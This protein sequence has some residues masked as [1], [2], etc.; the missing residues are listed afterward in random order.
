MSELKHPYYIYSPDYRESSGGIQ[1][2]HKLCHQINL[3]GGQAWMVSCDIINPSWNTPILDVEIYNEHKKAELIPVA[4]YSE[5]YSGNPINADVCV[6]YML[7][8]EALLNGNRLNE[9]EE[10][11]FFWYS[12]QL[13]VKE[14]HV[15]FLTM[16]GPDLE[17]FSEDGREK[18]TKLLY[19]NRVPEEKVDF[20]AL[21]EDI[22]IISVRNPRPLAELAEILKSATVMYTFEWSGTCNLAA[23]C[24]VPVV[25]LVARGYEK[26]A[27]SDASIRD[28]GGAGVCFSDDPAELQRTRS[29]LYKVRDHMRKFEDNFSQQLMHF[30]SKTQKAAQ[31]KSEEKFVATEN[32]LACYPVPERS[33][34]GT[35][36]ALSLSVVV[37]DD[38]KSPQALDTTLSLLHT[39]GMDVKIYSVV[40]TGDKDQKTE[41]FSHWLSQ[42]LVE[43]QNEWI[44]FLR[45]GDRIYPNIFSGL[46]VFREKISTSLAFYSDRISLHEEESV[47]SHFLPDFD[48]DYFLAMPERFARGAFFR[49]ELCI[50]VIKSRD[51][52]PQ[53]VEMDF[54]FQLVNAGLSADIQHI[55]LPLLAVI[56]TEN[57]N[58]LLKRS[59]LAE[60]LTLRGYSNAQIERNNHVFNIDFNAAGIKKLTVVIV[61]EDEI[62]NVKRL[63][64]TFVDTVADTDYEIIFIDNHSGDESVRSWLSSLSDINEDIF[65]VYFVQEKISTVSALNYALSEARGDFTLY[66]AC[67]IYFNNK[68]WLNAL[69]NHCGRPEILAC[70]PFLTDKRNHLY[71]PGLVEGTVRS[72]YD[73]FNP[74]YSANGAT[75]PEL[76]VPRQYLLLSSECIMLRTAS[77]HQAGGLNEQFRNSHEAI[78]DL[79]LRASDNES[80]MLAVPQSRVC[81]DEI[82][83]AAEPSHGDSLF[84]E[85]WIDRLTHDPVLNPNLSW[86]G[87]HF[88]R[89]NNHSLIAARSG[90]KVNALFLPDH[91]DS[92]EVHRIKAQ[93]LSLMLP[94]NN[95]HSLVCQH[96]SVGELYRIKPDCV[97]LSDL[98]AR[99]NWRLF[100]NRPLFPDT[101][102]IVELT[103][104]SLNMHSHQAVWDEILRNADLL[105]V[106]NAAALKLFSHKNMFLQADKLSIDWQ[107]LVQPSVISYEN[108]DKP[109]VGIVLSD[110]LP[111]DWRHIEAL[112]KEMSERV[113]WIIY[114]ACP[115]A[116]KAFIHEYHRKVPQNRLPEMF[117]SL[118]LNLALAPLS[119][120]LLNQ[121]E[122][123]RVIAQ[124]GA[125]GYPVL[126]SE[127]HAFKEITSVERI[128]NKTSQWRFMI[129]KMISNPLLMRT[130]G[131]NLYQEVN[132]R[133]IYQP[134]ELPM[135]LTVQ[136]R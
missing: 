77:C 2:L 91:K 127:H 117:Q 64:S 101:R 15:D 100:S 74:L 118:R 133:W 87:E 84:S 53:T 107:Q 67:D 85:K 4:V 109:R 30:F 16:V 36:D 68:A 103:R 62:V 76:I 33:L 34:A 51:I 114:G 63:L 43:D 123:H 83:S 75:P 126:A 116:W 8:H 94:G 44:L 95:I 88:L 92:A 55:P 111:E 72:H 78:S 54:I 60:H 86:N 119:D 7:N 21:P 125:C 22:T 50:E 135:W 1:A 132:N 11:L 110:L 99:T 61:V 71:S 69:L 65:R 79:L 90:L 40:A 5:I 26:L 134:G 28:M 108:I 45:S 32:W 56:S 31:K 17:M 131:E 57:D 13:I 97:V 10:D 27:I 89:E 39:L 20:S 35:N 46:S 115:D 136:E 106:R 41:N 24:G 42:L 130:L 122:G 3:H 120:A 23:L 38:K 12:S 129:N 66:L 98:M 82:V 52:S 18:T 29:G 19:L 81:C 102:F 6:R 58:D 80:L 93:S 47:E 59:L 25:S 96:L 128:K 112:I 124:L 105:V 104:A 49:R 113:C 14:P 70:A 37:V 48:L 121:A 73:P 9:T